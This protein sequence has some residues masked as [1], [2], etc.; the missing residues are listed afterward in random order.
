MLVIVKDG[1]W[2]M[3]VHYSISCFSLYVLDKF[4]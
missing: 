4:L 2:E 3:G 1:C